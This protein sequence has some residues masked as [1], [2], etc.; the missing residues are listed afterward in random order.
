MTEEDSQ[1]TYTFE[2]RISHPSMASTNCT[3]LYSDRILLG[4]LEPG[5]TA[6]PSIAAKHATSRKPEHCT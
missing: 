5:R 4:E 2:I 3:D 6:R 1:R